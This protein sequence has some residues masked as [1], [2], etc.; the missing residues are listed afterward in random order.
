V[1]ILEALVGAV[2]VVAVL[3]I[4]YAAL[5]LLPKLF[6]SWRYRR[7]LEGRIEQKEQELSEQDAY[8]RE[9]AREITDQKTSESRG[10]MLSTYQKLATL[11]R[12]QL[13]FELD[14]LRAER[15]TREF[16]KRVVRRTP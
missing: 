4:V 10:S 14:A 2:F 5:T 13:V 15:D 8:L 12:N 1:A 6:R 11:K 16:E 3:G 9:I 7:S